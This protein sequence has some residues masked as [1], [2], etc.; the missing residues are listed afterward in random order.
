[1]ATND[2]NVVVTREDGRND[3]VMAWLPP[4]VTVE[5]VPLTTTMYFDPDD[6]RVAVA[7][8]P[9]NGMFRS[10][11]VTSE[12]S[13][14]YA[15]IALNASTSDVEVFVVGSTTS[16]ALTTR[17]IRVDAQG[18]GTADTLAPHVS[19]GPVLVLGAQTMR[20]ELLSILREKGLEVVTIA[21]YATVGLTLDVSDAAV[22]H[23]ADVIFIGAPSAWKVAGEHVQRDAW[24][25][26][27]GATTGAAVRIDHAQVIEGWG[28]QLKT[29]LAELGH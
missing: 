27:P 3:T 1:L 7:S 15:H 4:G 29:R 6:V 18:D 2:V 9:S 11:I 14:D 25:V 24:V 28:P 12:R 26:V 22:V 16:K 10:L 5:E 21:C 13:A 8:S 19:R 23:S 20:D 17:G